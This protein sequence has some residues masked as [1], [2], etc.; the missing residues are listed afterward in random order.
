[1]VTEG[2]N[3]SFVKAFTKLLSLFQ[4]GPPHMIIDTHTKKSFVFEGRVSHGDY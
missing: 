3:L 2:H 4:Y 1:M